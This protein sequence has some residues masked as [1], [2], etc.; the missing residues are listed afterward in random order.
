MKFLKRKLNDV[1]NLI[2]KHPV[3]SS[4]FLIL[5][6]FCSI[7]YGFTGPIISVVILLVMIWIV[8]AFKIALKCV[9]EV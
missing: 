6:I 5:S 8:F 2:K 9:M 7:K 1:W 3:W 4:I